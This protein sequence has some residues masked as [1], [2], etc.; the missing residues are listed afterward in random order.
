MFALPTLGTDQ[1]QDHV[2]VADW[3][4]LNLVTEEEPL[5]SVDDVLA[6]L[7]ADPQDAADD[8][9]LRDRFW[10]NAEQIAVD[11]IA[12]LS[13]RATWLTDR[14]P[15]MMSGQTATLRRDNEQLDL[16]QFVTLLR[17]RQLYPGS[18][19][20]DGAES[21]RLFEEL[22][23]IALAAYVGSRSDCSVRFGLAGGARGGV[24][25]P[26]LP[27]AIVKL[28]NLMHEQVGTLP[29]TNGGDYR[30]DTV[31]WRPFG[32]GRPGQLVLLG[33]ATISEGQWIKKE[34]ASRWT[35]SRTGSDRPIDFVARPLTAVAFVESLTLTPD[36]MLRGL[37]PNFASIPLDRLRLM[38][39]LSGAD[40]PAPL[41]DSVAA[42]VEHYRNGV[43]Q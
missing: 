24:L 22:A 14:Y 3:V 29:T 34:P 23:T 15:L 16:W 2:R 33:Q 12:E 6:V 10:N 39:V 38:S 31:A 41:R 42:W 8:S 26:K 7:A 20:D 19:G 1:R 28:S 36:D 37:P 32:D 21:G 35:V 18:L 43:P 9:E 30:A 17:A 25:P 5:Y 27:D 11:A 13:Q 4:E 40:I